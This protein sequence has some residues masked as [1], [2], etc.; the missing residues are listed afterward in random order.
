MQTGSM[1]QEEH[2]R[3]GGQN[4]VFPQPAIR[5]TQQMYLPQLQGN[6]WL[7]VSHQLTEE[8]CEDG[9]G[10]RQTEE[11]VRE[12]QGSPARKP[13]TDFLRSF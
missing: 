10:D 7:L 12:E 1:A 5:G 13:S 6:I 9:P 11:K 3:A 2:S 4:A 8:D